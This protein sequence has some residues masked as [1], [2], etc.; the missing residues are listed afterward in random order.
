MSF[1]ADYRVSTTGM[2]VPIRRPRLAFLAALARIGRLRSAVTA[3]L[4]AVTADESTSTI[5]QFPYAPAGSF[6]WRL[7]IHLLTS[8]TNDPENAIFG[9]DFIHRVYEIKKENDRKIERYRFYIEGLS[10]FTVFVFFGYEIHGSL[11]IVGEIATDFDGIINISCVII[12][13]LGYMMIDV[14]SKKIAL[15]EVIASYCF[16]RYG[17]RNINLAIFS[18]D[19]MRP[20]HFFS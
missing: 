19:M 2:L 13:V 10:V 5:T 18:Y 17:E 8:F 9:N 12:L 1:A 3:L 14:V 4:T 16:V 6:L 7:R 11:P 15:G 20:A